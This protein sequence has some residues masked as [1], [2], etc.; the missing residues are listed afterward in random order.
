MKADFRADVAKYYDLQQLPWD[1]VSFYR[2]QISDGETRV[3][4]LGCGTGRVLLPLAERCGYI[5][6]IDLSEGMLR[7]CREKLEA[8]DIP[9]SKATTVVADITDFDLGQLFDLI[10]APFRVIQN[11]E[12]DAQFDGLFKCIREHLAPHGKCILNVNRSPI[13]KLHHMFGAGRKRNSL[14]RLQSRAVR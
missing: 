3:L 4:E 5:E 13:E 10:I 2:S 11:L 8:A 7:I 12:T 9:P 6:G 1:D 14:G